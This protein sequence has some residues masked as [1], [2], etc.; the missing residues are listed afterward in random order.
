[1]D[2]DRRYR[3]TMNKALPS[4]LAEASFNLYEQV[5]P[6]SLRKDPLGLNKDDDDGNNN[7]NNVSPV[8]NHLFSNNMGDA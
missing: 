1:M 6:E 8:G 4:A 2:M 3:Q 7:N 5:M